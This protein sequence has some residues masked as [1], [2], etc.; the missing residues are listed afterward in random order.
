M[1]R[2]SGFPATFHVGCSGVHWGVYVPGQP[3]EVSGGFRSS[4][5]GLKILK[6]NVSMMFLWWD[7]G[8]YVL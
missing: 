1:R 8:S 7:V 2:D 5:L 4:F 3:N 6:S